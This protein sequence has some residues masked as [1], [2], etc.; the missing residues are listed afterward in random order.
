[1]HKKWFFLSCNVEIIYNLE[2]CN[3][4]IIFKKELNLSKIYFLKIM[5]Y[6]MQNYISNDGKNFKIKII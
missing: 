2:E 3:N 1:M 6:T 4:I 5:Y